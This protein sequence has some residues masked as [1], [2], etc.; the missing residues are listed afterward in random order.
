MHLK[1]SFTALARAVLT[2]KLLEQLT[3]LDTLV[4][5]KA[6]PVVFIA[7][8]FL[9]FFPYKYKCSAFQWNKWLSGLPVCSD[10]ASQ[11]K[12][13]TLQ[14]P[15]QNKN[16]WINKK[17]GNMS[18]TSCRIF[19]WH[20]KSA[21]LSPSG[22]EKLHYDFILFKQILVS[23]LWRKDTVHSQWSPCNTWGFNFTEKYG[24]WTS[25]NN[26]EGGV[27][28]TESCLSIKALLW[29]TT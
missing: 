18:I 23:S 20:G 5:H 15:E 17:L 11:W 7:S 16:K 27:C 25:A 14:K 12:K 2:P 1:F 26:L 28:L 13:H 21:L 8:L 3:D 6:T 19:A 10:S 4:K 29:L 22:L 24:F 9:S